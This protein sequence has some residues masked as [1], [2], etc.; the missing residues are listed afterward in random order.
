MFLRTLFVLAIALAFSTHT[1]ARVAPAPSS[2]IIP[3]PVAG[4]NAQEETLVLCSH[5]NCSGTCNNVN[6]AGADYGLCFGIANFTFLSYTLNPRSDGTLPYR[7]SVG[8][9]CGSLTVI[10]GDVYCYNAPVAY[11]WFE[12]TDNP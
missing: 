10:P 7:V 8:A 3:P 2:A 4:P 1:D 12:V 9:D 11:K 5:A 6:A